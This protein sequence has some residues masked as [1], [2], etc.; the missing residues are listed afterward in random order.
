MMKQVIIEEKH[1]REIKELKLKLTLNASLWEQLSESQ[2]RE[3]ITRQELELTKRNLTHY[4]KLIERLYTQLEQLNNEKIRLQRYKSSK[5]KKISEL[6][7]KMKDLEILENIDLDKI[8]TEMRL[9]DKKIVYL[10]QVED[11][12]DNRMEN[13]TKH[14]ANQVKN[15]EKMLAAEREAKNEAFA[16]LESMRIE[17]KALEGTDIKNDLWKDKCKELYEIS[18]ELEVE[19]DGLRQ[20]LK[21]LQNENGEITKVNDQ[22]ISHQQKFMN[23]PHGGTEPTLADTMLHSQSSRPGFN[24][25]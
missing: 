4:E 20:G 3:S 7:S 14:T 19:N 23:D 1:Q 17:M 18:K 25:P 12:F 21:Q 24:K 16:K 22:L 8:L 11:E 2:K 6:E 10:K 15:I 9:R 5:Q 13:Q